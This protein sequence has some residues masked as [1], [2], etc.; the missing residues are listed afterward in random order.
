MKFLRHRNYTLVGGSLLVILFL[1]LTDPNGGA[2]TATFLGQLA[3][4]VIAVWFA[5]LARK[6]LFDY[7]D[8]EELY[9]KAKES[10]TGSAIVFVGVCLVFFGLLGLFGSSARAQDVNTY[11]PPKATS[12]LPTVKAELNTLWV[13]HPK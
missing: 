4:P 5:Y 9:A 13:N 12:Y 3:T 8:M 7:L 10:T 2:I 6:A 1:Y 11:I